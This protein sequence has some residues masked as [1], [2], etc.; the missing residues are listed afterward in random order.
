MGSLAY[1]GDQLVIWIGY[2]IGVISNT[3][4]SDFDKFVSTMRCGKLP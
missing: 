1:V 4:L 2:N 3:L